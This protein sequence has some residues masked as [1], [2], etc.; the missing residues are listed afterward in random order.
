MFYDRVKYT[1]EHE[2]ARFDVLEPI[3]W[4]DDEKK[5][6]RHETYHGITTV[7]SNELTFIKGTR[8]FLVGILS[9]YGVN[10]DVRLVRYIR[11]GQTDLWEKDYEGWVDF[12]TYKIEDKKFSVKFNSDP[13]TTLFKAKLSSNVEL[14]RLT[15]LTGE[16]L[17]ALKI[18]NLYNEGRDILLTNKLAQPEL[19]ITRIESRGNSETVLPLDIKE[20][21]D[22][23]A[24]IAYIA[25]QMPTQDGRVFNNEGQLDENFVLV[26]TSGV[27]KVYKVSININQSLYWYGNASNLNFKIRLAF[28]NGTDWENGNLIYDREIV[29][30]EH[31]GN[32]NDLPKTITTS[33]NEDVDVAEFETVS[34][35]YSISNGNDIHLAYFYTNFPFAPIG[36]HLEN[37]HKDSY[38]I[39]YI[40]ENGNEAAAFYNVYVTVQEDSE[41]TPSVI[42]C[43]RS[44]EFVERMCNIVLDT[45]LKSNLLARSSFDKYEEDGY[46]SDLILLHGMW[47][48]GMS[49]N[50]PKYKPIST[51]LRDLLSSFDTVSPIGIDLNNGLMTLEER[52]FFYQ[53]YVSIKLGEVTDLIVEPAVK[54]YNSTITV[55]YDKAGGYEEES[56]LDEYNRETEYN[57]VLN[58]ID[59]ELRLISIYRADGY[60]LETVRR[61]DPNVGEEVSADKDSKFDDNIWFVDA[62]SVESQ[63]NLVVSD[64]SK[65]FEKAP[66]NVY[67][68]ETAMNIWLS[69]INIILRHGK[70][71][72]PALL[73]YLD[74]K[75]AF[76]SS[77]GN[78]ELTTQLI[79]GNEYSQRNGVPVEDLDE[80]AH[81]AQFANFKTPVTW[82]QLNGKTYEKPNV[83]GLVEV[84]YKGKRYRG[85][86]ISVSLNSGI[87]DF[88]I[89]L[90]S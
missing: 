53:T 66:S 41:R 85:H 68:P 57:T 19:P 90:Y 47:A 74:S 26:N 37:E 3:N 77:E 73:K 11:N 14:E 27:D 79:G 25:S 52:G 5:F 23:S 65:R 63:I 60:G 31:N 83:Y 62:N 87:G 12:L 32:S 72:K 20:S 8:D 30:W 15:S 17:P 1:M 4:K 46:L 33:F 34:L 49:I 9:G 42:P 69:P 70:W 50:V 67:S 61:D 48:R 36:V 89:K 43:I 22:L 10:A 13:L 18:D 88:K 35:Q 2:G 39:L 55:G 7:L 40:D 76:N 54:D 29:L 59:T 38:P 16:N 24:G 75:I 45:G 78:S 80:S 84:W 44:F 58:K 51:S 71:I 81:K 64:W 21:G 82:D 28:Y 86:I 56:G 6:E